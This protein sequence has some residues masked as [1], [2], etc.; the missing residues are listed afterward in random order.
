MQ[1]RIFL[2]PELWSCW[3]GVYLLSLRLCLLGVR[4]PQ[5]LCVLDV[6]LVRPR[7]VCDRHEFNSTC[8]PGIYFAVWYGCAALC[9]GLDVQSR[10]MLLPG[11]WSC[12]L[13]VYLRSLWLYLLGVRLPV[14]A[15]DVCWSSLGL[16]ALDINPT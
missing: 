8:D 15:V 12:W 2:R 5:V 1:S 14:Y 10:V 6:L 7:V 9:V 3:L 13:G 16:C 11:L 4:L